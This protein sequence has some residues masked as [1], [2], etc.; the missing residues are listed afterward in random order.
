MKLAAKNIK[1]LRGD[2]VLV[3]G[4]MPETKKG[5][6]YLPEN[7]IT[8]DDANRRKVWKGEIVKFGT[9]VDFE[10]FGADRPEIKDVVFLAPESI[11]CPHFKDGEDVMF[12]VRDED[13]LAKETVEA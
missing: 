4:I 5:S 6:L 3:K 2:A 9:D 7:Y 12:I 10:Q 1:E 11:D 8:L 13:I